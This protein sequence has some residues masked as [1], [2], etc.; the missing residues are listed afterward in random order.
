MQSTPRHG[1]WLGSLSA[2]LEPTRRRRR[3]EIGIAAVWCKGRLR[4]VREQAEI[5]TAF[6]RLVHF[7]KERSPAEP[8]VLVVAPLSGHFAALLRD[9]VAALLVDH[10]VRLIDWADAREVPAQAGGFGFDDNV[11]VIIDCV[12]RLKGEVHL[13]GL[14]Q[15]AIP[16]LAA[17]ALL[18]GL[19]GARPPR[20][21]VLMNG[22]IDP[23]VRPTRIDRL[24][25]WR[26][27][28]WFRRY[29]LTRVPRPFAGADRAI[30]PAAM[31]HA[32]LAAYLMRQLATGGELLRKLMD[33][34]GADA[35]QHPFLE[36][37]LSLM[38]LPAE[39]FLDSVRLVFQ[40]FALPRGRLA[41]RG[42]AVE[43][44]AIAA[45]ALMTIEA[46]FDDVSAPGQ[47]RIAHE[48]CANIPNGRRAHHLQSGV[49]HFGTF[50]GRAWRG[51][52][53]PRL[54]AFIREAG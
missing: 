26:S 52:V 46:E 4:V 27:P 29:A 11:A 28:D 12:R 44:A 30:Y 13:V 32:A 1:G 2:A 39:F 47:T 19:P 38:D 25:A 40:E 20:S 35:A 43:P 5:A 53:L 17:T 15:S 10:D 24:T 33:D 16:S 7:E 45:T 21:L 42:Q 9:M 37:Y 34:D 23:R 3:P 36:L 48:L 18:A 49:G 50:H 41:W 6:Y 31:Q 14:C 51:S 22:M 54:A 8:S